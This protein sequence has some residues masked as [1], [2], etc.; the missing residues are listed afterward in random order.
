MELKDAT[1]QLSALAQ[2][3]RLAVFRLL[4]RAGAP[5]LP[6]GQIAAALEV[7]PNTLSSQLSILSSAGLIEGRRRGRS[8]IY[9]VRFE[10]VSALL[11]YLMQDC[12]G[13]RPEICAPVHAAAGAAA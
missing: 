7:P 8:V 12:C 2:D 9:A 3:N 4:I 1:T 10:R 5:G 11:V 13:G 6:A